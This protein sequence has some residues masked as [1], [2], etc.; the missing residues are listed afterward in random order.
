MDLVAPDCTPGHGLPPQHRRAALLLASGLGVAEVAAELGVARQTLRRWRTPEL[1]AL[2]AHHLAAAEAEAHAQL[3][4]ALPLAI[5][6]LVELTGCNQ[7]PAVRLGAANSVGRLWAKHVEE[8]AVQ[9]QIS[10]LEGQ[11][12]ELLEQLA[13]QRRQGWRP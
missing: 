4:A 12:A 7:H 5:S 8:V 9:D 10:A 11:V 6:T 2:V 3:R 1:T 13:E